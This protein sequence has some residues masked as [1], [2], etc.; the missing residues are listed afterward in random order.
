MTATMTVGTP[1]LL[2]TW[3]IA[4]AI[5]VFVC[6]LSPAAEARFSDIA[7]EVGLDTEGAK[8]GVIAWADFDDD[9]FLDALFSTAEL[10][11][12]RLHLSSGR[13]SYLRGRHRFARK[14]DDA[15]N[16]ESGSVGRGLRQ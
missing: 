13:L 3:R 10:A 5:G 7:A 14:R 16:P 6:L 9:G 15:P 1:V 12:T 2:N 4:I 8:D 11:A